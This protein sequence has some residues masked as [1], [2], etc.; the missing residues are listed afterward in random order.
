MIKGFF[1]SAV[2]ALCFIFD[3]LVPP[4]VPKCW[5]EGNEEKGGSVSLRC[6]SSQGSTPLSYVWNRE[7][8]GAMPSTATQGKPLN[9]NIS[10][11][12]FYGYFFLILLPFR[13]TER[14]AFHKEPYRQQC[15]NLCMS[16]KEC[17]WPSAVQI[18]TECI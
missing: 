3:S 14:R 2:S 9:I 11:H 1:P 18:F 10:A 16:G 13:F 8:G 6:K 4:S 5:V 7:S 17:S 12:C 15:W